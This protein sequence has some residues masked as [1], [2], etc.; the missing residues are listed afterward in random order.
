MLCISISESNKIIFYD[1]E[2]IKNNNIVIKKIQSV[3]GRYVISNVNKFN[4]I[5]IAGTQGIYLIST[6]T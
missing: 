4:Y 6:E 1:N 3:Y 5:F 2:N